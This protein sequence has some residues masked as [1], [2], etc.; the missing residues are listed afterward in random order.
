VRPD[1]QLIRVLTVRVHLRKADTAAAVSVVVSPAQCLVAGSFCQQLAGL[2]AGLPAD[3]V[4][5][6]TDTLGRLA[7]NIA[8][9]GQ[10]VGCA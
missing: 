1:K 2:M 7:Y 10:Q 6:L 5:Q 9:H 4:G 3:A 8:Q